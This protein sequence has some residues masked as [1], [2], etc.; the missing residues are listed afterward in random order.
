MMNTE[1][2]DASY[3]TNNLAAGAEVAEDVLCEHGCGVAP[4][5]AAGSCR[6]EQLHVAGRG[7]MP[8]HAA[9][10][11]LCMAAAVVWRWYKDRW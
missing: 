10:S 6:H 4:L 3:M 9:A 11:I 5:H 2:Y 8:G 7:C 1:G